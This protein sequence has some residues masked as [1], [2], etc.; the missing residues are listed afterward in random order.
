MNKSTSTPRR[1]AVACA[2]AAAFLS[3]G[4]AAAQTPPDAGSL[5]QQ[6]EQQRRPQ[7]PPKAALPVVPPP[8]LQS[9]GGASVTVTSFRFA[10]NTLLGA[11][12]LTPAV[13][14][15]LNRPLGFP[16]LQAAATAVAAAYRQ[17]GWVV[18]VYLPQQ[19]VSGGSVTIQIVEA[20]FG[21]VRVE[22]TARRIAA[23]RL[24]ALVDAAL[25]PGA[26]LNGDALD[27]AL[28]L[29]DDLPG[30][31]VTGRLS[32]GQR[33]AETDLVLAV[34]DG[35]LISGDVSADNTGSRSTGTARLLVSASLNSPLRFGDLASATLL[36]TRGSDYLRAAYSVPIGSR[37]WRVGVNASHLSYEVVLPELA[38]LD[39]RGT[40]TTFGVDGN[41]PLLRSRLANLY[42]AVTFDRR[43]FDNQSAGATTTRYTADSASAGLYGNLFDNLGGGGA[44]TAS[45]ALVQGRVDLNG[46]P[47]QAADAATTR[48]AGSFH[49]LRFAVAR[50]QVLTDAVSLFGG[51]SGQRAGKNLD[52]SEKLFLGGPGGVR[53]YPVSEGGGSDGTLLNLE[54][55]ARLPA[56]VSLTGFYD[57]GSVRV[58]HDN[59]ITGAAVP[60]RFDLKG[61]GVSVGWVSGFGL[62]VKATLARRIGSN[63]NATLTGNDQ[64]GSFRKNRLWLQA[65]LP[66]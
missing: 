55:R 57:W 15:F 34:V 1:Q 51:L 38:Q 44:N 12:R 58:N 9:L 64:D 26:A 35:P 23:E 56:N 41:Y 21:A 65:S 28:L 4:L 31:S 40:S 33:Q 14:S 63:P 53:A 66:F 61:F 18:R 10:G 30:V 36:H 50:Q 17:A 47:N 62:G 13:A 29:I 25:A 20:V 59:D 45:A 27:R 39:A 6:I 5:L 54:V 46:S 16:E 7:L 24:T 3:A 37:G 52:S 43:R 19:D 32:E 42:T 49:K 2:A 60:N 11:E 22:G 48:T 8:P